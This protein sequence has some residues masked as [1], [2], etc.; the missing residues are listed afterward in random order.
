MST[1]KYEHTSGLSLAFEFTNDILK[2][3]FSEGIWFSIARI[4]IK[5]LEKL[6]L[7]PVKQLV[8]RV[9]QFHDEIIIEST[10]SKS[11][12]RATTLVEITKVYEDKKREVDSIVGLS[13]EAKQKLINNL[14]I[15]LDIDMAN[16]I[17]NA[18]YSR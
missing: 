14:N 12:I 16:V 10:V 4:L 6:I 15:A 11:R 1:L 13:D 9:K 8:F 18:R 3:N 5:V 7:E 17:E 2:F